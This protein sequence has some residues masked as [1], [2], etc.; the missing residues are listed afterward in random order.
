MHVRTSIIIDR[1]GTRGANG[2]DR[3]AALRRDGLALT[4]RGGVGD[5]PLGRAAS[6]TC[7]CRPERSCRWPI[8]LNRF[9]A[10]G[11]PRAPNMRIRLFGCIL[12]AC[13]SS[14]KP[15]VALM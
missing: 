15:T 6:V 3:Y 5:L 12:I 11:F 4:F 7:N 14:S 2:K 13:P 1:G 8:M 10:C 9:L